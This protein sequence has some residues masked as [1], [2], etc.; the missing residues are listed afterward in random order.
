MPK[1]ACAARHA[2][3]KTSPMVAWVA[4]A[5]YPAPAWTATN[6][7]KG[8]RGTGASAPPLA[9]IGGG[10]R[11]K[12]GG[13]NQWTPNQTTRHV[14]TGEQAGVTGRPATGEE[15]MDGMAWLRHD[16]IHGG[17]LCSFA[18]VGF[19]FFEHQGPPAL[20]LSLTPL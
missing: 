18:A 8:R 19:Q 10:G 7:G 20:P 14:V 5:W 13:D 11:G 15:E 16:I 6:K 17:V 1:A 3:A 2:V 9:D 4:G 12:D